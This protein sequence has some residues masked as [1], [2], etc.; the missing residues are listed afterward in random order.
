MSAIDTTLALISLA[1]AKTYLKESTTDSDT[2]ITDLVNE[3]SAF[4]NKYCERHLLAKDYVEYYDGNGRDRLYLQNFPVITLT[5][6][7]NATSDRTF[8]ADSLVTIA[9]DVL[10]NK[11]D[12]IIRLW[13]NESYFLVAVGNVEVIYTAGWVLASVPNA[14]KLAV[15]LLVATEYKLWQ[16]QKFGLQSESVNSRSRTWREDTVSMQAKRILDIYKKPDFGFNDYS[17][18]D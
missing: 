1:E 6:L 15:K 5:S 2:I 3:A 14:L 12:G 11:E 16:E 10:L 4:C 7:Y 18:K 8:D 9:D 13:N 17:H